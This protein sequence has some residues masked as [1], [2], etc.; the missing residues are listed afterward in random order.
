MEDGSCK[1]TRIGFQIFSAGALLQ[2][3]R[4]TGV[5]LTLLK[6]CTQPLLTVHQQIKRPLAAQYMQQW[7]QTQQLLCTSSCHCGTQKKGP[8]PQELNG[9][10][11]SQ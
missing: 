2:H 7:S 10:L 6:D 11:G 3:C 4:V 1:P 8:R 5:Y 9:G